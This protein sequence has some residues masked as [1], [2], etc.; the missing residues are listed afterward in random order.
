MTERLPS[1]SGDRAPI[2]VRAHAPERRKRAPVVAPC[3]CSC[4]CC[5]CL[6]TVGGIIGVAT[7]TSNPSAPS[8]VRLYWRVFFGMLAV[9][10]VMF[11]AGIVSNPLIS[12]IVL[13]LVLPGVQFAAAIASLLIVFFFR[14]SF[15]DPGACYRTLGK[16]TLLLVLGTGLG[17]LVM[18]PFFGPVFR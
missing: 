6:H 9:G 17:L 4:C 13:L 16:L 10:C 1:P 7:A 14:S 3:A 5:C 8:A 15:D 12:A 11:G 2:T 18:L